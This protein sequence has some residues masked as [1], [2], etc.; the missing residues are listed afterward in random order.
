MAG[1]IAPSVAAVD[2]WDDFCLPDD[3]LNAMLDAAGPASAPPSIPVVPPAA[4]GPS[5]FDSFFAP[6]PLRES[7]P[8]A[9]AGTA[10]L[11]AL[12]GLQ[13]TAS[14]ATTAP[15]MLQAPACPAPSHPAPTAWHHHQQPPAPAV[16]VAP[17]APG[18]W[19]GA[20][21]PRPAPCVELRRCMG[22]AEVLRA[23]LS[24]AQV[25]LSESQLRE[26]ALQVT[27]CRPGARTP[28]TRRHPTQ[29]SN[30]GRATRCRENR[31]TLHGK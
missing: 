1:L 24:E 29:Q 9:V 27:R 8:S 28:A 4:A 11:G 19:V 31:N 21:D 22:E 12:P 13:C 2:E 14:R 18:A 20:A 6:G 10:A 26:Q 15:Q 23:R 30:P 25:V 5:M 16:Q 17:A 3:V 7:G